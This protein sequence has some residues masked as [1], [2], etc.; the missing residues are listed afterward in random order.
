MYIE[1]P[2]HAIYLHIVSH[3]YIMVYSESKYLSCFNMI[4]IHAIPCELQDLATLPHGLK[5]KTQNRILSLSPLPKACGEAQDE[6]VEYRRYGC[7]GACRLL[8]PGALFM[9]IDWSH[10][11]LDPRCVFRS[12][13]PLISYYAV[14]VLDTLARP[15]VHYFFSNT[16][17]NCAS[18]Y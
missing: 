11:T 4:I 1:A 5:R 7:V 10:L 18:L 8:L 17:E 6:R 16:Q 14:K 12:T 15:I 13:P 9:R 3:T 2:Q